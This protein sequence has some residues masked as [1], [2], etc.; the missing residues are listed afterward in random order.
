MNKIQLPA[1]LLKSTA[2]VVLLSLSAASA[3]P[4]PTSSVFLGK[5]GSFT[6]LAKAGVS[7]V[8][9]SEITGRI[10]VSP[11][12]ASYLTGFSLTMHSSNRYA[13]SAQVTGKLY[14][15]NFAPPVPS[16]LTQAVLDM[17][18]AFTDAAGRAPDVTELGAGNIGG[19]TLAPGVYKWGTGLLIPTDVT[20]AGASTDVW[21]FQVAQ[22]MI[23]S[24]GAKVVLAGGAVSRNIFWQV[25]GLVDI[26]TTAEVRGTILCATGITLETGAS[27]QGR[28]LAQTAV[29]LDGNRVVG[30]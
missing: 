16:G 22:D 3:T 30:L 26:G 24:N 5:A 21:I 13:T 25:T 4:V 18:T 2:A 7:T 10:G 12:P 14:A 6:I 11:A 15:A 1:F 8:P 19:L 20:L 29:V 23:V 17:E 27:V 9:T 28:L